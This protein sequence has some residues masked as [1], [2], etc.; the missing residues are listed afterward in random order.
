MKGVAIRE[1]WNLLSKYLRPQLPQV[2]LLGFLIIFNNGLLLYNPQIL[3]DFINTALEQQGSDQLPILALTFIGI[4]IVSQGISIGV[5]YLGEQIGW[6]TTNE[7][8]LDL[9]KHCLE[10]DMSFHT[11]HTP[12]EM[13]E[14]LDGDIG[15]LTSFFSSFFLKIA[16]NILLLVGIL[17]LLFRENVIIGLILTGFT[18][19]IMLMFGK[20]RNIAVPHWK[21]ANK[22]A[23]ELFGFLEERL[24]GTE[25][26]RSNGAIGYVL[27]HFQVFARAQWRANIKAHLMSNSMFNLGWMLFTISIA[28]AIGVSSELYFSGLIS[29]GTIYLVTHYT[30]MLSKPIEDISGEMEKL[31]EAGSSILRLQEILETQNKLSKPQNPKVLKEHR[32]LGVQFS[33]V[34]F[35]Y[36][37]A[38]HALVPV[39]DQVSFSVEPGKILGVLGHTGSGKTTLTRL[40][41]RMY[42]PQN[43]KVLLKGADLR[44]LETHHLRRHVGMVTQNVQLFHASVR[45]NLTFF[46]SE[47]SDKKIEEVIHQLG[48]APWYSS[49]ESGLDTLLTAD[50]GNLSAG[51]AQLLAF[52]R[53]FLKD[54]GIVILDEASSRLDPAT[55]QWIEKA[56]DRL[57]QGRTAIIIAH[58]LNTVQRAD[59]I[60]VM[61][62][63]AILEH[64]AR[65]DLLEQQDSHFKQM[66]QMSDS[67]ALS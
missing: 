8:R 48:L 47:I 42:D 1:Y 9:A 32:P 15:K 39:L 51:E 57:L 19:F 14:R 45:D 46:N 25:D 29:L 50:G 58:R 60:M 56:I 66:L 13:I 11:E 41:T 54:P 4:S 31:Q 21:N 61:K 65:L 16:A 37:S 6:T 44:E 35:S 34:S 12:G 20:L 63:G 5:V 67:G 40:L 36:P 52:T 38:D 64:G 33:E 22:A 43:G 59:D 55:E 2:F 49:L 10:L 30:E 28:V 26:I 7:L 24:G 62:D 18:I 3:R 17:A 23:A 27:H 53:I